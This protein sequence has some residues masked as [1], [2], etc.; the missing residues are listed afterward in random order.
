MPPS[1]FRVKILDLD[2]GKYQVILHK[3]DAEAL[4]VHPGDRVKT[5]VNGDAVTAIVDLTD[6]VVPQGTVGV[7]LELQHRFDLEDG[8]QLFLYPAEKPASVQF[9]KDKMHRKKLTN[10]QIDRLVLDV[11]DGTLSD[12]ELSAWVTCLEINDMDMDEVEALTRAMVKYGETLDF[13]GDVVFDKH[14]IGGVPGN[15]IT[16]LVVPIVASQGLLIPKTSSR[17]VTGA[18]GTADVMEVFGPVNLNGEEIKRITK[19]VGGVMCWGGGVNL[20]PADDIIIR[21]EHPLSIDPPAQLLASVMAKKKA[22]GANKVVMDMPMGEGTKLPDLDAARALSRQFIELG[23]RL[24]MQVECAVTYGGQPVGKTVGCALEANEA[25][26]AL[27]APAESSQS[28]VEKSCAIAGII[29]EM[30]GVAMRGKGKAKALEVLRSGA[31]LTK[32]VE[33]VEAQGG[34]VPKG[35]VPV[36]KY[37]AEIPVVEGGYVSAVRNKALVAIARA[38]GSPRDHGAGLVLR[39]KRGDKVEAGESIMTIYAE[40]EPKLAAAVGLAK[41][42][43]PVNVEGMLL[44]RIPDYRDLS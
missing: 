26:A 37:T 4:G 41:K 36:G 29:L 42:L 18:A 32:F 31:A 7:F 14:S 10:E 30:G 39:H 11:V 5:S 21:V 19:Q 12:V 15:K 22:V 3:A 25:L 40:S 34:T 33:I 8:A 17:A 38:A 20:A 44:Q 9:I 6:S 23:E 27:R 24:D 13:E 43:Q 16:L 28:L 1:P 35:E 2:I